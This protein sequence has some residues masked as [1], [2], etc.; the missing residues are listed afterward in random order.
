MK[1]HLKEPFVTSKL[2]IYPGLQSQSFCLRMEIYG[3]NPNP[4]KNNYLCSFILFTQLTSRSTELIRIRKLDNWMR[5]HIRFATTAFPLTSILDFFFVLYELRPWVV[6]Q[7]AT[8]N[9]LPIV[10]GS[11]HRRIL[12]NQL[13]LTECARCEQYPSTLIFRQIFHRSISFLGATA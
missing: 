10:I 9:I 1:Y 5:M 7:T 2:L 4:G 3:C 13:A 8:F 11:K 12:H 6:Q